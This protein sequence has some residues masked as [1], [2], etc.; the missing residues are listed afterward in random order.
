MSLNQSNYHAVIKVIGVGGGGV[1]AVNRMIAEGLRNSPSLAAAQK[2][3]QA[4]REGLRSQIGNSL[5]P[6]VD[7]GFDPEF[8]SIFNDPARLRTRNATNLLAFEAADWGHCATAWQR[9]LY[10][11]EMRPRITTSPSDPAAS[12]APLVSSMIATSGP[13]AIPTQPGYRGAGG[14]GLDAI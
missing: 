9:S 1:N 12:S 8:V 13:A 5:W 14:S 3:L 7:V 11:P 10:P 6:S 2:T 4:A